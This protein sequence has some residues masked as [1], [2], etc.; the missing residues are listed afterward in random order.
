MPRVKSESKTARSVSCSGAK[1]GWKDAARVRGGVAV[2]AVQQGRERG[3]YGEEQR[4]QFKLKVVWRARG[5]CESGSGALGKV[6]GEAVA[7]INIVGGSGVSRRNE[8]CDGLDL[9]DIA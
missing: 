8:D 6:E 9:E 4:G 5:Q 2:V 1:T 7:D 3:V